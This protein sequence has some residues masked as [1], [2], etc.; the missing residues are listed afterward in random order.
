VL[1]RAA[2]GELRGVTGWDDPYEA[3][4]NPAVRLVD[5]PPALAAA[6][7]LAAGCA[8]RGSGQVR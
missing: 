6:A 7:V 4:G 5:E 2:R 3:P 1:A 8:G